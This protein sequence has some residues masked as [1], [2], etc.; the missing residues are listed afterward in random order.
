MVLGDLALG[1]LDL[2]PTKPDFGS[3]LTD[4]IVVPSGTFNVKLSAAEDSK[5]QIFVIY[6]RADD[7]ESVE[8]APWAWDYLDPLGE[9]TRDLPGGFYQFRVLCLRQAAERGW[10]GFAVVRSLP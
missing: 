10:S 3:Y 2:P 9:E 4:V 1:Y 6:R 7:A 8:Q 5:G